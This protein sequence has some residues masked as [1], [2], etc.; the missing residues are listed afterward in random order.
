MDLESLVYK[1]KLIMEVEQEGQ[2]GMTRR[3][4]EEIQA[5]WDKIGKPKLVVAP[6]VDASELAWRA[7][8]RRYNAQ[9]CFTPMF[10]SRIFSEDPKYRAENFFNII[11]PKDRPLIVQ[12]CGNDPKTVAKAAE[13]VKDYCDAVDINLGCPQAIAKKGHYGAYLQNEW[14]LVSRIVKEVRSVVKIPVT[15]KIRVFEDVQKTINYAKMIVESGCFMLTVHGRTIH[16]KGPLTGLANWSYIKAVR[17]AINIPMLANGNIQYLQDVWR[18]IEETGVDGVLSAEGNLQNPAI[19]KGINPPVWDVALEYLE[20]VNTYPCPLS[21]SRGHLFKLFHH[22]LVNEEGKDLRDRLATAS[23]MSDLLEMTHL[24]KSRF[25]P[26][27]TGEKTPSKEL[28]QNLPLPPWL[29]QPYVRPPPYVPP[30]EPKPPKRL[31]P[32]LSNK[33][34]KRLLRNP[35]FKVV[36]KDPNSLKLCRLCQNPQG[37]KCEFQFCKKCC[38]LKCKAEDIDC[39]GHKCFIKSNRIKAQEWL[40]RQQ[41][42]ATIIN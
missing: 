13:F 35:R 28:L 37:L 29:C 42:T 27:L 39:P 32:V 23:Y 3:Y 41:A 5:W 16:Q 33:M 30:I 40:Q 17:D 10:H 38:R 2:A 24:L 31:D 34:K 20:L 6:M 4:P 19:F 12:F 26:Y 21:Y 22:L 15:C 36:K 25:E 7:L 18:C 8:S 14:D 11:D 1:Y 9:L